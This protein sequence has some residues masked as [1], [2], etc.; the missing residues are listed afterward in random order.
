M[1]DTAENGNRP[2]VGG[3]G[4]E[5]ARIARDPHRHS[6]DSIVAIAGHP[7]HA[8]LVAFPITLTVGTLG[9][10]LLYWWSGDAFFARL[11]LWA[12][13][14]GFGMGILSAL[15]GTAELLLV[16]GIRRRVAPWGHAVAAMTLLAVLGANWGLRLEDPEGAVFP[17]GLYLSGLGLVA[18][19]FAG[20]HGGQLVFEHGVGVSQDSSS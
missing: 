11:S 18:V 16:R 5:I 3:P 2:G 20:W 17:W 14:V 12:S 13:G 1:A 7:I 19:G 6:V 9:G 10:D 4:G 15:S 8:M